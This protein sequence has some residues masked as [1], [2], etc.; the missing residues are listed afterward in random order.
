MRIGID[1]HMVGHGETGNETYIVGLV[2]GLGQ[3]DQSNEYRIVLEDRSVAASLSLR[4]N[5]IP[6]TIRPRNAF[7][8]VPV[9]MPWQAARERLDLL[10]VTYV[11]PPLLRCPVVVTV[12]DVSYKMF[13]EA[14]S[15]RDRAMLSLMVPI[16]MRKARRVITVSESSKRDIIK[17]YGVSEEKLRV[18]HAAPGPLF[19]PG[20]GD[21]QSHAVVDRY[22]QGRRYILAVGNLQPRKNLKR[23][24]EAYAL[25]VGTGAIEHDLL[26]VGKPQWRA[27]DL[28]ETVRRLG[29]ESRVR[30]TGYVP[31]DVLPALY[32]GADLFVYASLYEG[33]GLPILEAMACGTPVVTSN[34]SSMPEVA[35][36]A[37]QLVDPYSV[38]QIAGAI[39]SVV[40]DQELARSLRQR[41]LARAAQF[42]WVKTARETLDVYQEALEDGRK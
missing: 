22:A 23:L 2:A 38:E 19:G 32:R 18:T 29:V 21:G 3:V 12:H 40:S 1:A 30:F 25:L 15:P 36:D 16:S 10:H 41:G 27:T 11:A 6:V 42:S 17:F 39:V 20:A 5:F 8:R 33:F 24:I 14:F 26:L 37:A 35:A 7:V 31:D 4:S 13:P 28:L 34:T 9:S